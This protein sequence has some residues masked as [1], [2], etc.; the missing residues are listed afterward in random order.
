MTETETTATE[1]ES[2]TTDTPEQE[3]SSD[4]TTDVDTQPPSEAPETDTDES[5]V[6]PRSYVEEL[7]E[8]NKRYRHRAQRADDYAHRLHTELVRATS[9]LADPT[10]LTFDEAH[11]ENPDA[12]TAAVDDL[13]AKKPHLAAR[14]PVGD[15]GAR[16]NQVGGYGEP[17]RTPAATSFVGRPRDQLSSAFQPRKTLHR[18]KIWSRAAQ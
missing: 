17:R 2:T 10:D 14:R 5:D 8:E 4:E 12:L 16:R 1:G 18:R 15:I 7:R 13:L 11:I 3:P 6:F 9:R